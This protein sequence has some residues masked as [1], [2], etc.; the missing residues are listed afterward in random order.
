[1]LSGIKDSDSKD[2]S[3]I[4][5]DEVAGMLV[6]LSFVPHEIMPYLSAFISLDY[7]IFG[8]HGQFPGQI[9]ILKVVLEFF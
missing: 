2:H 6:A 1:M 3:A 8:S 4:V 9:K 7:L 5:I